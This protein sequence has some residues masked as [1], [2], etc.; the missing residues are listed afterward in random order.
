MGK[1]S[2]CR[3]IIPLNRDFT[4]LNTKIKHKFILA[5][6][7]VVIKMAFDV[8]TSKSWTVS[9][10]SSDMRYST[11]PRTAATA[12]ATSRITIEKLN[13]A[14]GNFIRQNGG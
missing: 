10:A 11:T 6:V 7:T 12:N 1:I 3:H 2:Y 13:T 14:A 4:Q 9:A 5:A 8:V